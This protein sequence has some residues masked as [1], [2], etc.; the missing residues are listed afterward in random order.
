MNKF[1]IPSDKLQPFTEYLE[2]IGLTLKGMPAD[3]LHKQWLYFLGDGSAAPKPFYCQG[4]M[5][6]DKMCSQQ[7]EGCKL[8]ASDRADKITEVKP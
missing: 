1:Y 2:N 8:L 4:W 6:E 5:L 7:C 3:L